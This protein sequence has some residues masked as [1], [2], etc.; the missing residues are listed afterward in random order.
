MFSDFLAGETQHRDP[1]WPGVTFDAIKEKV[2]AVLQVQAD[3]QGRIK[4]WREA[5]DSGALFGGNRE[6][7]PDY[8]PW[9]REW[10]QICWLDDSS[11]A[12]DFNLYRYFQAASLHRNHVLRELL[13][14]Q[15]LVVQ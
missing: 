9:H 3:K 1:Q 8:D 6:P 7:I 14:S 5:A 10:E 4:A 15:G 12:I 11:K 2:S 13:P